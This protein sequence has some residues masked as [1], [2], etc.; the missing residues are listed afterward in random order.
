MAR[1]ILIKNFSCSTVYLPQA[2]SKYNN[3]K[4]SSYVYEI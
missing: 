2:I 3:N 1:Y 4:I